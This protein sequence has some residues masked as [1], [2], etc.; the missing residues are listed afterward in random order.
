M[1]EKAARKAP[2]KSDGAVVVFLHGLGGSKAD[3]EPV[4]TGLSRDVAVETLDLPGSGAVP[5]PPGGFSPAALARAVL[6]RL[7]ALSARRVVFVGHSLGARVAGEIAALE[8]A[9]VAGLGLVAPLGADTY[10]LTEKLKWKAMSRRTILRSVPEASLRSA[11]GVGFV[12]DGPAKAAFVERGIA[13]RTGP[14]AAAATEAIERSVDGVLDALP[15]AERLRG[16]TVPLLILS[17]ADDPLAPP[18]ES[19]ALKRARPDAKQVTLPRLGHYP[20]LED[21]R[22]VEAELRAFLDRL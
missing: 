11:L 15:L 22:R 13:M 12:G 9:R 19:A 7:P 8:G 18:A 14:R 2:A 5:P 4:A 6:E 16:T 20:M 1:P 21:P 10:K 17:G 3:W